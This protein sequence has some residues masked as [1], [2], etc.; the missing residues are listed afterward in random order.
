M[1]G[2][3]I[4]IDPDLEK[5]GVGV[6]VDGRLSDLRSMD[7]FDLCTFIDEYHALGATFVVEDVESMK[8][9]F[10]RQLKAG[11]RQAQISKISQNVGQVKAIARVVRKYL[12]RV[13]ADYVMVKPLTG[14]E[15][16]RDAAGR[17]RLFYFKTGGSIKGIKEDAEL[18][19][20]VT[21][22]SGQSNE[23][24]RD[25]AMLALY[26]LRRHLA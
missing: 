9:T 3:V 4:G 23:D 6:A 24:K 21:G 1:T 16:Y 17:E 20:Q 10:H 25:A 15:R 22:W 18:F 11:N 19:N 8:P 5:S 7:L 12:D 13:G 26:G 14:A 2:L